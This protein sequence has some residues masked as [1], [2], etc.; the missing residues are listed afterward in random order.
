MGKETK[1]CGCKVGKDH[2]GVGC[3]ALVFTPRKYFYSILF[4]R[5]ASEC[6]IWMKS[7]T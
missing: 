3:G 4:Q 5:E 1:N 6:I 7:S 2:I